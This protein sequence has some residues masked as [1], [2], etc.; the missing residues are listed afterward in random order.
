MRVEGNRVTVLLG[1]AAL[2]LAGW[3]NFGP[4]A[5]EQATP[6]AGASQSTLFEASQVSEPHYTRMGIERARHEME[7]AQHYEDMLQQRNKP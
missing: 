1:A 3:G 7:K 2:V 6:S 4:A 5:T